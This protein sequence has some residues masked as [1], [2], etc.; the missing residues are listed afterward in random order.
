MPA[1]KYILFCADICRYSVIRAVRSCSLWIRAECELVI[2]VALYHKEKVYIL[3][4]ISNKI[5]VLFLC[6]KLSS[7]AHADISRSSVSRRYSS[8]AL[9]RSRIVYIRRDYAPIIAREILR[10]IYS[11]SI[12]QSSQSSGI[13]SSLSSILEKS[14]PTELLSSIALFT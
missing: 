6:K 4:C 14:L 10:N 7:S 13:F 11:Y 8:A 2:L 9:V 3:V 5:F 1:P 12:T